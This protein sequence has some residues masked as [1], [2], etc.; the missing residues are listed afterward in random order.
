[1]SAQSVPATLVHPAFRIF[2]LGSFRLERRICLAGEPVQFTEIEGKALGDRPGVMLALLKLLLGSQNRYATKAL[3]AET[4]WPE[5]EEESAQRSLRMAKHELSKLLRTPKGHSLLRET[6]DGLGLYLVS[7]DELEVDADVFEA[8]VQEAAQAEHTSP[9]EQVLCLWQHAYDVW[10]GVYLPGDVGVDWTE[11]RRLELETLYG[12][13][14]QRLALL[15]RMSGRVLEAERILRSYWATHLTDEEMLLQLMELMAAQGKPL[16]ALRFYQASVQALRQE[17]D[18]APCEQLKLLAGQLRKQRIAVSFALV[19]TQQNLDASYQLSSDG[20]LRPASTS[21]L[22]VMALE[23]AEGATVL[24]ERTMRLIQAITRWYGRAVFCDHLQGLLHQELE[25]WTTMS[26][27]NDELVIS[28]RM[29]LAT[30]VAMPLGLVPAILAGQR[31]PLVLEEFLPECTASLTACW[32][33]MIEEEDFAAVAAQLPKYLPALELLA[34]QPSRY[35]KTAAHLTTQGYL[36]MYHVALGN[37]NL[38]LTKVYCQHAERYSRVAEDQVLSLA[39]MTRLA[40]TFLEQSLSVYEKALAILSDPR[41][42]VSPSLQHKIFMQAAACYAQNGQVQQ[43]LRCLGKA[44]ETP[45]EQ[46]HDEPIPNGWKMFSTL[47]WTAQTYEY[48]GNLALN[49]GLSQ[50]SRVLYTAVHQTLTQVEKLGATIVPE[51]V[52]VEVMLHQAKTGVDLGD[53]DIFQT[54]FQ[55]GAQRAKGL[56]GQRHK[57]AAV[58]NWRLARLRWPDEMVIKDLADLLF[59]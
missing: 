51:H 30:L 39:V 40:Y 22:P 50:R 58:D 14:V 44:R 9:P 54:Y 10:T 42:Q 53:R 46:A 24:G 27:S 17:L 34:Q 47:S 12:L 31:S 59:E 8:A 28:R 35:Q 52:H 33:A 41:N 20:L 57:Q 23:E 16:T 29:A 5:A 26:T 19:D 3:L 15:S 48:L 7:Q 18:V 49:Q 13:C 4:L 37:L 43:A 1:M 55:A 2:V 38:P 56:S 25:R 11:P 6:P 32:H 36:L 45:L 21:M